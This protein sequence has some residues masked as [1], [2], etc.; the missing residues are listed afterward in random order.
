MNNTEDGEWITHTPRRNRRKKTGNVITPDN[1]EERPILAFTTAR[2]SSLLDNNNNRNSAIETR[3]LPKEEYEYWDDMTSAT[4]TTKLGD[5]LEIA[6]MKPNGSPT[7]IDVINF[8][9]K[10]ATA[11]AKCKTKDW[12]VGGH[13]YLILNETEYREKV[14]DP[15]ARLPEAPKNPVLR[16]N[17][18][19]NPISSTELKL[20][21]KSEQVYGD[22]QELDQQVKDVIAA[23]FPRS[24]DGLREED[25]EFKISL[26]GKKMLN[27]LETAVE[28]KI[29][30]NRCYKSIVQEML[31]R[32]YK[33]WFQ[34]AEN[35]RNMSARLRREPIP[36]FL[37]IVAAQ[38]AFM[39]SGIP[40]DKIRDL[41]REWKTKLDK[42]SYDENTE[43][44]YKA[45]KEHYIHKLRLLHVDIGKTSNKAYSARE[46]DNKIADVAGE[47]RQGLD[48][49]VA[50]QEDLALAVR[51]AS[52]GSKSNSR[53]SSGNS[54]PTY[55]HSGMSA[56]SQS[57]ISVEQYE[58]LKREHE[59]IKE[60]LEALKAANNNNGGRTNGPR[61]N[62]RG[63]NQFNQYC[64][65]HGV[66]TSH[67]GHQ[68]EARK[69]GHIPGATFENQQGGLAEKNHKWMKWI[70]PGGVMKDTRGE[71]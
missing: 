22:H 48:D 9:K 47:L 38:D 62:R 45:F 54:V 15:N 10:L 27:H 31:Q 29:L 43:A 14:D 67:N 7:A 65:T 34:A 2:T 17:D 30:S 55:V 46:I 8:K 59:T 70:G 13:V 60:T 16:D 25:G 61:S 11:L 57:Q 1:A 53:P 5:L 23:L 12:K 6:T 44:T 42:Y 18:P 52:V 39:D 56:L 35:D 50:H 21:E 41:E 26:T 68:C 4:E 20:H 33:S 24:L 51:A 28:D 32:P 64:W 49:I 69:N 58:S 66:N 3:H 63:W 71:E 36:Y 40:K 37:I 19:K